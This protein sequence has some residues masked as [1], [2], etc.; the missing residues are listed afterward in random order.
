MKYNLS[1]LKLASLSECQIAASSWV[2]VHVDVDVARS[3]AIIANESSIVENHAHS[4]IVYQVLPKSYCAIS[5]HTSLIDDVGGVAQYIL[6]LG[7]AMIF[8]LDCQTQARQN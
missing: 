6:C 8:D 3:S 4:S 2:V 7:E 1:S 5:Y